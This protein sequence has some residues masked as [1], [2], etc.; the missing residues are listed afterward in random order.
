[1]R[2]FV[3]NMRKD[4]ER[5]AAAE[6]KLDAAGVGFEFFEGISGEEALERGIF[7]GLNEREFLL[8]TGRE[9]APGE[10]GCFASHRELW[11]L[12]AKLGEP[13]MI[14]EDDFELSDSFAAA[15][16]CAGDLIEDVGYL[17]LQWS[18]N[19]RRRRIAELG[20]LELSVYTKPPHCM[21]CYCISPWVARRFVEDTRVLDAPVDVYVKKYWEHGQPLYALTPYPVSASS[22]HDAP[23]IEGRKKNGKP[24]GITVQ[25]FLR[26]CGWNLRRLVFNLRERW[27]QQAEQSAA[28]S[29]G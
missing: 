24:I 6:A 25:R 11:A 12:S 14:M 20:R 22:L 17:R 2:V 23:T 27:S 21:M 8:N 29:A 19:A 7:E 1:M 10:I 9:V 28:S 5:R 13:L 15:V 18:S 26:K 3:I 16:S 4:T